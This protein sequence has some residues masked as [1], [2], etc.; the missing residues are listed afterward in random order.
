M[1]MNSRDSLTTLA[2]RGEVSS[3]RRRVAGLA[4]LLSLTV[5]PMVAVTACEGGSDDQITGPL[6]LGMTS[7]MAAYYSDENTTIYQAQ[8]PVPLPVRKPTS[9]EVSNPATKGTPYSHAPYLL[10]SDE[11]VEVH[12]VITNVDTS[13]HSVWLLVDPWNEFVRWR[14]GITVVDDDV[15]VPN[16]GYNLAFSIGP[17][18]RVEGTI[19]SDDFL[20]IAT[21]LA[22]TENLLASSFAMSMAASDGGDSSYTGPSVNE[23]CNNIFDSL[24]RSNSGDLLYMPW[25]PP[26]IAGVTG[27]DLGIRTY[28]HANVA[29]EISIDI[30]DDN[31]NRFVQSDDTTT[32][33][34][35]IPR[36]VLSP[37]E[38]RF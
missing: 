12:Y 16:N 23:L 38:A 21:K 17:Q 29:V 37:P 30:V 8:K 1:S 18:S 6:V 28:E 20:E 34:I 36:T 5:V 3:P 26:V 31:G 7:S 2:P 33:L 4:V 32:P 35:G 10:A 27:F 19:T 14:P 13:M 15:T 9:S 22:S 25:I 11:S 24:N